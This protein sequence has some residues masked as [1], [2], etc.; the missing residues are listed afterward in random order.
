MDQVMSIE[1]A[2]AVADE[3][4]PT[5]ARA[6]TALK[7]LRAAV[8]RGDEIGSQ[9]PS[10]FLTLPEVK[11][12]VGFSAPTIYRLIQRGEFPRQIVFGRKLVRWDEKTLHEWMAT[13][14]AALAPERA[15]G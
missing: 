6:V 9:G 5:P 1:A 15:R 2:L 14:A 7:V 11:Q 3:V 10:R 4:S 8:L 13:T 12:L